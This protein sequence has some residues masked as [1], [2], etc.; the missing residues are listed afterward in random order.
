MLL[1]PRF[2]GSQHHKE[3]WFRR[4]PMIDGIHVTACCPSHHK[5]A[6]FRRWPMIDCSHVTAFCPPT[7]RRGWHSANKHRLERLELLEFQV[8]R[9]LRELKAFRLQR[10]FF[11]QT[12][13][14][15]TSGAAEATSL[16]AP[17][18]EK[19]GSTF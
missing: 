14:T 1:L 15:R 18:E 11:Q 19:A 2:I 16:P 3:A 8:F 9:E 5:E 6:G 12:L 13:L 4:W 17:G 7:Q 10:S